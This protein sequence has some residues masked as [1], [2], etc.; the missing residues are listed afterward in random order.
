MT[1]A[2][3]FFVHQRGL[4]NA[5]YVWA[6]QVGSYLA[7]VAAGFITT[8]QGWRWVWWWCAIFFGLQFVAFFFGFEESKFIHAE[9]LKAPESSVSST[10]V[11]DGDNKDMEQVDSPSIELGGEKSPQYSLVP[12]DQD[13]PRKTYLQK[14]ALTTMSPGTWSEF[15][16]HSWQPFVILVRIPG[17]LFC[18]CV[19]AIVLAYS[20]VQTTALSTIMLDPPYVPTHPR[21]GFVNSHSCFNPSQIQLQCQSDRLDEPCAL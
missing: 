19:Y 6:E 10:P 15:F 1:I 11:P 14:L 9:P 8:G 5:V 2:D 17:V 16:R 7:V 12:I 18:A 20:T 21:A 13:I 4:K 3:I